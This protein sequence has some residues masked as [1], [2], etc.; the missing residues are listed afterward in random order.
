MKDY[1]QHGESL[2]LWNYIKDNK[3][4]VPKLFV[5]VG[6]LDGLRNSNSKLFIEA[7]WEGVLIE[8]NPFVFIDIFKNNQGLKFHACNLAISDS[9]DFKPFYIRNKNIRGDSKLS[10]KGNYMVVTTTLDKIINKPI[11]ILDIDTE[12]HDTIIIQDVLSKNIYPHFIIIES[13]TE[14]MF[15]E[16]VL[17]LDKKYNL[18]KRM[19]VNSIWEKKLCLTKNQKK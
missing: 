6:A 16:Q 7:G 1:S 19:N 10:K 5:D 4:E 13:N 2:F 14:E 12:G 3:L 15:R 9:T 8:P 11:G 18:I 17:I